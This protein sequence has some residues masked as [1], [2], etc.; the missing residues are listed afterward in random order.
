MA[1]IKNKA[2]KAETRG[3]FRRLNCEELVTMPKSYS[4]DP[5]K[6]TTFLTDFSEKDKPWD[7][8]RASAS[9]VERMYAGGPEDFASLVARMQQ[10]SGV[11]GFAR[12][13]DAGTGEIKYKLKTARF[14][15][16]RHCPVC[17]WR[18]SMR[19][20]A[21]FLKVLPELLE[22]HPGHRFLFLTLTVPN[23]DITSLRATLIEM[24]LAWKR[25]IKRKEF[26][27]VDGW[28]RSTEVTYSKS[29]AGDTH[30][31][32]HVFLMVKPSYFSHGYV[33]QAAWLTAWQ[34]AM[35]D[36]SISQ[37]DI[38]AMKGEKAIAE[39]LKY[40]VKEAD[41]VESPAWLFD[42]T[43]Q[44][45]KMRFIAAGG[46]LKNMLKEKV[47]EQEMIA[48]DDAEQ[49]NPESKIS[50]LATWLPGAKRYGARAVL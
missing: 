25:L 35:R 1:A 27:K 43:R 29:P 20:K 42:L 14:C 16:V 10:C 37:V 49:E 33:K 4:N 21:R 3:A 46:L 48:G 22:A 2:P 47:T 9:G 15:R 13:T 12:A 26:S 19:N 39:V 6:S 50:L 17:V 23:G 40:A 41:L 38:R 30:P 32:F 11:L 45:H 18:R 34:E 31:H 7:T 28:V 36:P 8:H 5:K 24:N 44:C